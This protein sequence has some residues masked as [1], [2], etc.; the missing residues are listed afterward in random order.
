[1]KID[2]AFQR[3]EDGS[4]Q[5]WND[6]SIAEFKSNR[7]QSLT[8][9]IIQNSL[10]ARADDNEAVHVDFEE[11]SVVSEQIPN[12]DTLREI[13]N[14]CDQQTD[15]QNPDLIKEFGVAKETVKLKK[16]PVLSVSDYNTKG[17]KGPCEPG[18]PFYQYL[19]T[20]GQSGGATNR[21]G[22]HGLG[23]AAPLACSD[24]RTIF[25]STVWEEGEERQGL[26]QGR[27]VL[28]SFKK[29]DGI[30]K[31]TGYWGHEKTYQALQPNEVPEENKWLIREQIG[32]TVHIIGWSRIVGVNWDKLIIGFAI[33][34]FFATFLRGRLVVKVGKYEV[35]QDNVRQMAENVSIRDVMEKNKMLDRLD[36]AI[37]YM[38]CLSDTDTVIREETQLIHL[39]RTAIRLI[40]T[41]DA[42]RKIALIRNDMLITEAVP[43]FWKRVPG[44]FRDFV[45]VVEVLDPNGSQLIRLM[46]PPSHNSLD[47]D[48]LPTIEDRKKGELVLEKLSEKLKELV[49]RHAGGT[50]DIFGKVNFMAEFFADEA[51]DDGG[52][53]LG[54]EIDPNGNFKFTPKA[55]KLP[56]LSKITLES[57]LEE[58]LDEEF[59]KEANP[60]NNLDE[61]QQPSEGNEDESPGSAG[62]AGTVGGSSESA[63]K[64]GP[65]DGEGVGGTGSQSKTDK[66][67]DKP[68]RPIQLKKVRIV[69][70]S[71]R[72][73]EIF[74]TPSDK[75]KCVFRVH[76]VGADFDDPFEVTSSN[77]GQIV[78]GGIE[79]SLNKDE[80][81]KITVEFSRPIFGGLKLVA[82]PLANEAGDKK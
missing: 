29:P 20:V 77:K 39:G 60:E 2:W 10:D 64:R 69:K 6:P 66:A 68:S 13:I 48:W 31:S 44:R 15:L 41:D 54:N 42:P 25:V 40:I 34:N 70:L 72:T 33:S 22:S 47:V 75:G 27:A 73:A 49:D 46:E 37:F 79:V 57:E 81:L 4:S 38:R 19:K 80:R 32:T 35:N 24:L 12:I 18:E 21:A 8:R 16:I 65:N 7:L 17:M 28:M 26:V 71:E 3:N 67:R 50:A 76:E 30:Y 51:G 78:R 9:E 74:A 36:D 58:E 63:G 53:K 1:M 11:R 43:G 5:G 23:K 56:P 52:G 55:I 59:E 62:G 82:S 45:G 14:L 61:G